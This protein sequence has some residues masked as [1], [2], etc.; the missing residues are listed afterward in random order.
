MLVHQGVVWFS[1]AFWPSVANALLDFHLGICLVLL[2]D[3][4]RRRYREPESV[5]ILGHGWGC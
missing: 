2:Q 5:R 1:R 4:Q 3:A